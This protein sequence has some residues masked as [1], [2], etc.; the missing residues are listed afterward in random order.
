MYFTSCSWPRKA[1]ELHEFFK[2]PLKKKISESTQHL[3]LCTSS[4]SSSL[5]NL[6]QSSTSVCMVF[7]LISS[8]SLGVKVLPF[9][10]SWIQLIS[11]SVLFT[12]Q[13]FVETSQIRFQITLSWILWGIQIYI[14]HVVLCLKGEARPLSLKN[15]RRL[16]WEN[17]LLS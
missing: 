2:I 13:R 10:H 15:Q 8:L 5:W 9:I 3:G 12:Q 16:Y 6:A 1:Q 11:H 7:P 4:H 14:R 17:S